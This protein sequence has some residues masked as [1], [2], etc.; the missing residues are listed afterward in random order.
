MTIDHAGEWGDYLAWFL[1]LP[2][3]LEMSGFRVVHAAWDEAS[4]ATL[5][6]SDRVDEVSFRRAGRRGTR[7]YDAV[8]MLIKGREVE[9][10][11][12]ESHALLAFYWPVI[13]DPKRTQRERR[14][15][16]RKIIRELEA[17]RVNEEFYEQFSDCLCINH[18]PARVAARE[19]TPPLFSK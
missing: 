12:E 5:N 17:N 4:I 11:A 2:L 14:V 3:Y 15:Q 19:S 16:S 8:E 9:L 7:E 1:T 6:G 10:P 13:G 18:L